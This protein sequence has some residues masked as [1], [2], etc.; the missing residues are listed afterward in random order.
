MENG[1]WDGKTRPDKTFNLSEVLGN[2]V[3]L[4]G[5]KIGKLNDIIITENGKFPEVTHMVVRRPFGNPS[6]LIPW[7]KSKELRGR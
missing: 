7:D 1:Y 4:N 2:N 3:L 6:L 5:E